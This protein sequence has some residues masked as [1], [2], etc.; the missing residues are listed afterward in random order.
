MGR[1]VARENGLR[2]V[3]L[4][5]KDRPT[6]KGQKNRRRAV[7]QPDAG[8]VGGPIETSVGFSRLGATKVPMPI[9]TVQRYEAL[10]GPTYPIS[11]ARA[12]VGGQGR[13][14]SDS[15]VRPFRVF[16]IEFQIRF[17]PSDAQMLG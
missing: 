7:A 8:W 16:A 10:S 5:W 13:L 14:R 9:S 17:A 1:P 12:R 2:F 4:E 11:A 15:K 3:A 6:S